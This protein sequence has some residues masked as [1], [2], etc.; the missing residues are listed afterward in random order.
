LVTFER[1]GGS[2]ENR[3]V[4]DL[5]VSLPLPTDGGKTYT[6]QLRP[7]IHYS[8]GALVRP[9]DVRHAIERAL[10]KNKGA[11][12]SAYFSGIVGA[13]ACVKRPMNCD[14]SN[15]IATDAATRTIT[16]HLTA[17][18]PDFLYKLALPTADA[19]PSS[20]AVDAP[21]P[22]PATGPYEIASYQANGSE[23][24]VRNPHF[25]EW[26]A[27]AQPDGYPND[28]TVT[29][30]GSN[31][32]AVNAVQ[33]GAADLTHIPTDTPAA[34]RAAAALHLRYSGRLHNNPNLATDAVFLNTSLP[35][36]NDLRVRRAFNYAIDRN[37]MV[38]LYGGRDA[39]QV[40]CQIL[41]ANLAGYHRYC[42]YT[43]HPDA[44]GRYY[45][46]DLATAKQLVAASGTQGQTITL[47]KCTDCSFLSPANPYLL[48]VLRQLGYKPQLE[49]VSSK[50]FSDVYNNP[51]S[52][53][54]AIDFGW[55]E[56]YPSASGFFLA[57]LTCA[58]S[59]V[60][61]FCRPRIDAEMTQ[62]ARLQAS[63]P[64]AA[65]R[66]WAKVDRDVVDQAPWVPY[67]TPRS[68]DFVSSRVGN[69]IYSSWLGEP[70][71]DQLWVR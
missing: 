63:E 3:L 1:A 16:F 66:L 49:Q 8:T 25:H 47:L 69:Y 40:T 46:P 68:T 54:Q 71:L 59:N 13:A 22:L 45:G 50:V 19:L 14:L 57:D 61:R 17:P 38:E 5:A 10:I 41:P 11:P 32:A 18:D 55:G 43:I 39:G 53:W 52:K 20:T 30:A 70:L 31:Q 12:P 27:A 42:P 58:S 36:F 65:A 64:Q 34:R 21:Y 26:S 44:S 2:A 37:H 48:S 56:D 60:F 62:A 67:A 7:G 33:H 51:H 9:D 29:Y 35:P 4:P 24:L 23:N 28:I 15:G 6:F